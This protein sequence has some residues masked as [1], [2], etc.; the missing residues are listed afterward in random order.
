MLCLVELGSLVHLVAQNLFNGNH[1]K[2]HGYGSR[3]GRNCTCNVL[4]TLQVLT[5]LKY[6]PS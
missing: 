5:I 1:G 6:I 4:S 2:I 3:G